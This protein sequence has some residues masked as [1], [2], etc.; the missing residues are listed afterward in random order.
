MTEQRPLKVFLCH[1]KA[2]KPAARNL[3]R[4][5]RSKGMDPWL[6]EEKLLPGQN[7]RL[8]I[9]K[10]LYASDVIIICLSK[11]SVDKEGYV[12]K[13]IKF[14]LDKAMEMP[15]DRIFIIPALLEECEVP[16][17]LK[18]YHWVELFEKN[19]NRKLM[20]SLNLRAASLPDVKQAKISDE[21]SPRIPKPETTKPEE[22]IE[23][24]LP[25]IEPQGDDSVAIGGDVKGTTIITG[26]HNVIVQSPTG[27][28]VVKP[29]EEKPVGQ[30]ANLSNKPASKKDQEKKP[31]R[32]FDFRKTGTIGIILI[33][34]LF[35]SWG[36]NYLLNQSPPTVSPPSLTATDENPMA[37]LEKYAT[38]TAHVKTLTASAPTV[39]S[40]PTLTPKP[41][42][43]TPTLGIGSTKI[44]E[45]DGMTLVFVPA[46]EFTMG[47][48]ADDAL[49]ECQKFTNGCS[50]SWFKDEEPPHSVN[51]DA[52]WIDQTEV[53]NKMYS[54]CIQAGV[55]Q[56][57][58]STSSNTRK[59]YYSDSKFENYPVIYV[60][61]YQAK[62][63]CEWAGRRLPTEA[64]WEKAA[65]GIDERIYPWG[66]DSPNYTL[67][68]IYVGYY[69]GGG[70]TTEV[71]K[72]PAGVSPYGALDMA[73]NVSEWVSSLYKPYPYSA[74]DGR[75]DLNASGS[76]AV[77]GGSCDLIS[78]VLTTCRG[79]QVPGSSD[80]STG[81]R[82][83]LSQ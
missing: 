72:Y 77:R 19:W 41:P 83:V 66:N 36:I 76:R 82:C 18:N 24:P 62:T 14:A 49:A 9:P 40:T 38:S 31:A 3:Y 74:S 44:S 29:K 80:N 11:N 25:Q 67:V 69:H 17:S 16:E 54:L 39:P 46:G 5:L 55:C 13:E 20:Q 4:Y 2:D 79:A 33:A 27:E 28:Y 56:P 61:W 32:K 52:F 37:M 35:G 50:H 7:W 43:P 48:K 30:I 57:P 12:Q 58:S 21:S 1:A 26:D 8:E 75:E 70:D 81:F 73:G 47:I 22:A 68:N 23:K 64:E 60:N 59:D 15:E 6:D 78:L 42:T 71:G 10:A 45:K 63:Y 53:T 51:L 65:R 34:L